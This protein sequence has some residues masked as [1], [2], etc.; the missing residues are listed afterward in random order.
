VL[1]YDPQ[2]IEERHQEFIR[3]AELAR[4]AAQAPRQQPWVR[5]GLALACHRIAD[6]LD[7]AASVEQ[8]VLQSP[9]GIKYWV[10]DGPRR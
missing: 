6:W 7:G 4:L 9:T 1:L 3:Q 5:H 10:A 8:Y 2:L